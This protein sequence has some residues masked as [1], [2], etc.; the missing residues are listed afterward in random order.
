MDIKDVDII[1]NFLSDELLSG[2]RN[3]IND[4][5]WVH[6]GASITSTGS[7]RFWYCELGDTPMFKCMILDAIQKRYKQKF[8]VNR[9]YANGQTFGQDGSFH[10]DDTLENAYTFLIYVSDINP[11]NVD[12]IGGFT[13]IKMKDKIVNIEPYMR[14]AVMFKSN[15]FHRGLAPSRQSDILRQTI[16]FKLIAYSGSK[17]IQYI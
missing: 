16:A 17:E 8:K 2:A 4:S 15:L 7:T 13:Q 11:Q 12:E 5:K 3:A 9:V 6:E 14:R 10:Q 1:D